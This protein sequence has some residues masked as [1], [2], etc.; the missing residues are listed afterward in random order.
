MTNGRGLHIRKLLAMS[1]TYLP[2][3]V[4]IGPMVYDWQP[5]LGGGRIRII[6]IIIIKNRT[7]TI[8]FREPSARNPNNGIHFVTRDLLKC[9]LARAHCI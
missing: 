4:L 2:S 9:D 5:H 8:G 7:I 1:F 3:L 6:I